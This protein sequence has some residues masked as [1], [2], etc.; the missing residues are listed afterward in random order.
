MIWIPSGL[1]DIFLATLITLVYILVSCQMY[2]LSRALLVK[3][4]RSLTRHVMM[5][6]K[7]SDGNPVRNIGRNS[8][9][10]NKKLLVIYY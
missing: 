1:C 10:N 6:T 4:S 9:A 3:A 7:V 8:A 5:G 2:K